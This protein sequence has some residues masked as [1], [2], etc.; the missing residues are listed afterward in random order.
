MEITSWTTILLGVMLLTA[1]GLGVQVLRHWQTTTPQTNAI[2]ETLVNFAFQ[3]IVAAQYI[4]LQGSGDLKAQIDGSDKAAVA[5]RLY[6]LL[7]DV[8]W[9]GKIPV[10]IAVV[11]AIV[12]REEFAAIVKNLYDQTKALIVRNEQYLKDAVAAFQ[13]QG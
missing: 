10:P 13:A 9:V 8:L 4:A 5:N 2:K 6:D 11:K 7:P 3:G 1:L 12:T